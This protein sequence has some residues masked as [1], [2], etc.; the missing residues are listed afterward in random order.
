MQLFIARSSVFEKMP[1]QEDAAVVDPGIA[2]AALKIV[3]LHGQSP[4]LLR[5]NR[6]YFIHGLIA[7]RGGDYGPVIISAFRIFLFSGMTLM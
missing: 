4:K 1:G 5:L 6:P 3:L 2:H 7:C